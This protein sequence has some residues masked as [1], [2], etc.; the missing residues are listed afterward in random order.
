[1][2]QENPFSAFI[3]TDKLSI[4]PENQF[5]E[6]SR[7]S[8]LPFVPI[9]ALDAPSKEPEPFRLK[10]TDNTFT[11]SQDPYNSLACVQQGLLHR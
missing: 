2:N 1:M 4:Q 9:G 7:I 8:A 10:S 3:H 6:I 5:R 11:L